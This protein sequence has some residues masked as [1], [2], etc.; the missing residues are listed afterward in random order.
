[1]ATCPNKNLESWKAL[2]RARGDM[3]YYLWDKYKGNVP[4]SEYTPQIKPGVE[5]LFES[6]PELA[7]A[8]YE[9]LGFNDNNFELKENKE[10]F[11][12]EPHPEGATTYDIFSNDR[13]IGK[14]ALFDGKNPMIKGLNL[15]ESERNKG[16]GKALYKW[17]N[18]KA[19]LK[20]GRLYADQ[21]FISLDAQRVWESLNK[22]GLV[23]LTGNSP[24]FND[25][26]KQQALQLYSQYL[27]TIFPDSQVKD[28]VYH[29]S[30]T[31]FDGFLEDNLNYF[32][33][34]EIAKGYGKNLY[35]VL[36]E[37]NK[38]YYEDGGN[39][40]NQSY[41]DLYDKLDESGSDG[42]IS[43]GKNLFVPKTEEQIHILGSK[44]DIEGF[45][46]FV[47]GNTVV[48]PAYKPIGE[49]S[50]L[51]YQFKVVSNLYNNLDKINKLWK[52]IGNNNTFW[53]KIQQDFQIPKDQINLLKESEGNTIEEKLTSFATNYSY[54]VEINTTKNLPKGSDYSTYTTDQQIQYVKVSDNDYRKRD[55]ENGGSFIAITKKEFEDN[56]ST[57]TNF[58]STLTVPGGTNYTENEIATPA[59]TPSIKGHA[60][61]A[62]D[63]GI[64]W[65]RSDNK[66]ATRIERKDLGT[67]EVGNDIYTQEFDSEKI[68]TT[69]FKNGKQI[70]QEEYNK[71]SLKQPEFKTR[72]ILEVQSDLFQKGRGKE[73]LISVWQLNAND[74]NKIIGDNHY[75][76]FTNASTG[77]LSFIKRK[78]NTYDDIELSRKEFENE[79]NQSLPKDLRATQNHFLQ[80]LNKDNNWVTFFVKSIVQD[81]AKKGYEKVLFPS[82]NT[83]SKVE[84]HTTLEEFKKQKEDRIKQIDKGFEETIQKLKDFYLEDVRYIKK[85]GKFFKQN[86]PY[87]KSIEIQEKEFADVINIKSQKTKENIEIE[88]NQIQEELKKLETEGFGALKPIYKF[89]EEN[90]R[91]ILD[92]LVGGN[93]NDRKKGI[94]KLPLITDEY[95]NTWNEVEIKEENKEEIYLQKESQSEQKANA[96]INSLVKNF[97][98]KIGVSVNTV[99]QIR[100]AQGNVISAIAKADMLNKIIDI[101]EGR[102]DITTL[103]EEAAHF[104]V[105]M[106]DE[107]N[108]LLKEM[109]SKITGYQIYKETLELYRND[110]QYRNKDGSLNIN[111]LKKEAIG[112]L[113]AQH[114]VSQSTTNEATSKMKEFNSWWSKLWNFI[115]NIFKKS[116]TDAFQISAEKILKA[117]VSDLSTENIQEQGDYYQLS[118]AEKIDQDQLDITLDNSIDPKTGQKRHVYTKNG[119]DIK[120]SV[121]S[122]YVDAWLKRKFPNDN[123]DETQKKIDLLKAEYGDIIH[124]IMQD[125]IDVYVD[126]KTHFVRNVPAASKSKYEGT[127][128]YNLFDKFVKDLIVNYNEPGAKFMRE[129]K[130][131]DPLKDVAGSIDLL[132]ISADG[133]AHIYD[134]KSQEIAKDQT[135]LKP[136]KEI[137]YRI[138]LQEYKKILQT[139]YDIKNFG[140]VRAI[141]IKVIYN[142]NGKGDNRTIDGI[143][144]VE[145]GSFDTSL[146]PDNKNYLLPV[147]LRDEKSEDI[148]LS[149]YVKKLNSIMDILENKKYKTDEERKR[150][151]IELVKYK[152]AVR[153]LQLRGD[154]RKFIELGN[155]EIN[156]YKKL[157]KDKKLTEKDALESLEILSVFTNTTRVFN[158]YMN[159]LKTFKK[160]SKDQNVIKTI[161]EI[162][163]DYNQMNSTADVVLSDM[164]QA[165]KNMAIEFAKEKTGITNL[166]E[167][168]TVIGQASGLFSALSTIDKKSF[169]VF[170]RILSDAQI[171]RDNQFNKDYEDL[172]SLRKE[173]LDWAKSKGLSDKDIFKPLLDYDTNGK[174][175]GRFLKKYN[176]E[177]YKLMNQA[178]QSEDVNW[179]INNTEFDNEKFE[180]ASKKQK[181]FYES[182]VYDSKNEA[183]N[184]KLQKQAYENWIENHDVNLGGLN[185]NK[186]AYLNM[187]NYNGKKVLNSYLKPKD[188]WKTDKWKELEKSPIAYKTY[189]YFQDLIK[190]SN[191]AG[192]L[193]EYTPG[194]IPNVHRNKIEQF[195]FGGD[196]FSKK[197]IFEKLEVENGEAAFSPQIN[198]ITGEVEHTIPTHFIRDIGVEQEDGSMDYS[199]KSMDLFRVFGV[200]S[201][202]LAN[203]ESMSE[204]EDKSRLLLFVEKN[205]SHIETDKFGNPVFESGIKKEISGNEN[206]SKLLSEFIN[207]YLYN[208][209]SG[210]M[211]DKKIKI[212]DKEYSGVKSLGW[213]TKYFS[214][215]TLAL[216]PL[217]G[218]AN[219]VGG[220]GNA[221]FQASK[222]ILFNTSDWTS[223]IYDLTKRDK[224]AFGLLGVADILLTDEKDSKINK[225]SVSSVIG[226][227][228][229]DKAYVMMHTSDKAVQYPVAIALMK[230]NM[231]DE[232]GKIVDIQKYVKA[233]YNYNESFFSLPT[234]EQTIIRKKIEDEVAL[235][236][237]TK[238]IYKTAEIKNDKIEIT[239]IDLQGEQWGRFRLKIKQVSKSILGNSTRDDINNIRTS[240]LGSMTMQFRSWMPQMVQERF[241]KLKYDQNLEI[242]TMGKFNLFFQELFTKRAPGLLSGIISASGTNMIEAAKQ[243]YLLLKAEAIEKG[244]E[245]TI[246]QGE[247]VDMYIGN[248]RSMY[249]E[250]LMILG[251]GALMFTVLHG[252]DDDD[253]ENKGWRAYAGRAFRKYYDEFSFFYIPSSWS[254][255]VNSPIPAVGL[256]EDFFKFSGA[257]TK[258]GYGFVTNDD[259]IM[260]GAK[261]AKYLAKMVP[262]F[263]EGIQMRAI[264]DEDF[265]KD[266]GIRFNANN[267]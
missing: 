89:Y 197:G 127:E 259:D 112:K 146:I 187:D 76:I 65:F 218:T 55:L 255:L 150:K 95:G 202:Q 163:N 46:E 233:K 229:I 50:N 152:N 182:I 18:Y 129:V 85:D 249:K 243:K 57:P 136:Y 248:I 208:I 211:E 161:D 118:G 73:D 134:W 20:G 42:F 167:G 68:E 172:V 31:T 235:L 264:F 3:A 205:K 203:Y 115:K 28:I 169:R 70:N 237:E 62:T 72:R 254:N 10:A 22:E 15:N 35:P 114:I 144:K 79:T 195:I 40:S 214:L 19:T 107:N 119:K 58:Y 228:T 156:K 71:A 123:R 96:E 135:E 82:G 151:K 16:L 111:K 98:E 6:N 238:S 173:Y 177:F 103:P 105:E 196:M 141:P 244:E 260:D 165:I 116:Q 225:L 198:P 11:G 154:I 97:L 41:E 266:W 219:F 189:E 160:E 241:G 209:Q 128:P 188:T 137:M 54:T 179:L 191:K 222:G 5:E 133:T 216:N 30:D 26:Q 224:L 226:A 220:T 186:K 101:I 252:G 36:I 94:Y 162:I 37:I 265:R 48:E 109:M 242:H 130:I 45:K 184:E 176:S 92:N 21:E 88:K 193:D 13:K 180:K 51:Q 121:T 181:E 168:E 212:G 246:T 253:D 210:K 61:F 4:E 251:I 239:G 194:F 34:K 250:F 138:Q 93:K 192:V 66:A 234:S 122:K 110:P 8:V 217:S 104:F 143:N 190:R 164:Q 148:E 131:H 64:G 52:Q 153:D 108:P 84:G 78:L 113:I 257:L 59:I 27:D 204:I 77:E 200:W 47:G 125:I 159:Q 126:P 221:F 183:N 75:L 102:A 124:E 155:F 86:A 149:E 201:A 262:I 39:L 199:E 90:V 100:D 117:D 171:K 147:T 44:Q 174:W 23:D 170:S 175:N 106:L 245:F 12:K 56:Q 158:T 231:V 215:K 207:Y 29:G 53:N 2:E 67:F 240:M 14:I 91:N 83:A 69:Y 166:L 49:E 1:M 33:T 232:N 157:I 236:K 25:K 74:Y 142:Y 139:H 140:L 32:G 206:N 223:S 247:F 87:V 43:N 120:Y 132:I 258:Q 9:A 38:P 263:K 267:R 213:L 227:N 17:L 80:L 24:K 7:N 63:K 99:N 60:Q 81:S 178:I 256:A 145:I 261:P 230:N 185:K